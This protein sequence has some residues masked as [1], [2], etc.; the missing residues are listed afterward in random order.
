MGGGGEKR[1]A[2]VSVGR[3]S[4]DGWISLK[5]KWEF[6]EAKSKTRGSMQ[7]RLLGGV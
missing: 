2:N 5:N 3:V 6:V 4:V 1:K 7:S